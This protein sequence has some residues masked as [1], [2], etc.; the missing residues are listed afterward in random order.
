MNAEEVYVE[1]EPPLLGRTVKK[2]SKK[3]MSPTGTYARSYENPC[4]WSCSQTEKKAQLL[5][6]VLNISLA[7]QAL[8]H[9]RTRT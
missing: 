8:S 4:C 6:C 3:R 2:V 1:G 9:A 7:Q 5:R